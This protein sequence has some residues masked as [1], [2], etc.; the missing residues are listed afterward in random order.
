VKVV[1]MGKPPID[2]GIAI[3]IYPFVEQEKP[4]SAA[5]IRIDVRW[6]AEYGDGEG[7][8]EPIVQFDEM[9][10]SPKSTSQFIAALQKAIELAEEMEEEDTA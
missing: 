2:G 7:T 4:V 9:W 6:E 10:M 8:F 1:E 5:E 3:I